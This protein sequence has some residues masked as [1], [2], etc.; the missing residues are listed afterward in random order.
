MARENLDV[1]V[2]IFANRAYKILLH[3]LAN[4]GAGKPGR[5]AN[6]M[7]TLDRPNLDWVSIARGFGVEAGMATTMEELAVQFK[8]GLERHGPYLVELVM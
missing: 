2:V 3:E 8:R 5:N 1:T 6:D 7:L 4:V